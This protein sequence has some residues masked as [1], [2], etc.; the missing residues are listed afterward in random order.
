MRDILS[1]ALGLANSA[2][3]GADGTTPVL[4]WNG[5]DYPCTPNTVH[6][7]AEWIEGGRDVGAPSAFLVDKLLFV[8]P[9]TIDSTEI[10]IDST[11]ITADSV[12]IS[13]QVGD[14]FTYQDPEA[15]FPL[16]FRIA[17]IVNGYR[18]F[19]FVVENPDT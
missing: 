4:T 13:P 5:V 10:T 9:V 12:A 11:T 7:S 19:K 17:N 15:S 18:Y 8:Q 16:T 14:T 6:N 1:A 3:A 2:M